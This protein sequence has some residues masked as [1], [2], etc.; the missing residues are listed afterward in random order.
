[1]S[2]EYEN[3]F[4][5][6][7]SV[8]PL[9]DR[10]EST[11]Q[12]GQDTLPHSHVLPQADGWVTGG[13]PALEGTLDDLLCAGASLQAANVG[14]CLDTLQEQSLDSL[15][16]L[17]DAAGVNRN[18]RLVLSLDMDGTLHVSE[19]PQQAI[20]IAALAAHPAIAMRMRIM[21][22]LALA[23]RGMDDLVLAKRLMRSN[24]LR[25]DSDS[26]RL[27]QACLKGGL[28]HFHLVRKN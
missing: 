6:M 12:D 9:N 16:A 20:I 1:M 13:M 2:T 26:T 28:S 14:E 17:L 27:F 18:E 15:Y 11:G 3:L 23:E 8:R 19:H 7:L 10:D 4:P 5:T 24:A 21:A 22:A 25:K